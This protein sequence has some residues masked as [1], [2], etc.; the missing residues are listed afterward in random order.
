MYKIGCDKN[1]LLNCSSLP[2]TPSKSKSD[3]TFQLGS[4]K[5]HLSKKRKKHRFRVRLMWFAH[6]MRGNHNVLSL[7]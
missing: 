3:V 2:V 5:T 6:K 4:V 1:V 7:E